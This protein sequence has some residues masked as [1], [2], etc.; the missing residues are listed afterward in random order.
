MLFFYQ[1]LKQLDMS[2]F[3]S[4]IQLMVMQDS[5]LNCSREQLEKELRALGV[6][7]SITA[8]D[9]C[10]YVKPTTNALF[11]ISYEEW[12]GKLEKIIV[13]HVHGFLRINWKIV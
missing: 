9:I 13:T 7:T 8:H 5:Q 6:R 12:E 1:T 2:T 4:K 3:I 11:K 10:V